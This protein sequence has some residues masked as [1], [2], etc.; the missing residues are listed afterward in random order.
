MTQLSDP[1]KQRKLEQLRAELRTTLA[2]AIAMRL[3]VGVEFLHALTERFG[4]D[5]NRTA[6]RVPLRR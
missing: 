4:L 1:D 2:D 6:H 3:E 5:L